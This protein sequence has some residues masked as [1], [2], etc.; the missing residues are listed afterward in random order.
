MSLGMQVLAGLA[1]A[2]LMISWAAAAAAPV[3]AK[4]AA[5]RKR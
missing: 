1:V 5:R 2:G 4:V 3:P